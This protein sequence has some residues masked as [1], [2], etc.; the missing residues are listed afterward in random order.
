MNDDPLAK[1]LHQHITGVDEA[2]QVIKHLYLTTSEPTRRDS[3]LLLKKMAERDRRTLEDLLALVDQPSNTPAGAP[4]EP[5]AE[6]TSIK[7]GHGLEAGHLDLDG[8]LETLAL[9]MLALVLHGKRLLWLALREVQPW[10][11]AWVDFDFGE[12][13]RSATMQRDRVDRW[14]MET[15]LK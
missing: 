3:L 2:A 14:R 4:A 7:L 5:M 8:M 15:A 9:E 6:V 11:E 10:I 12:L 13:E 1:Y